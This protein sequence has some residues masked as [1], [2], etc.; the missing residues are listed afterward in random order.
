MPIVLR[1]SKSMPERLA[2]NPCTK[3]CRICSPSVM[4]SIPASSCSFIATRTASRCPSSRDAPWSAHGA[5]RTSGFASQDGFGKLPVIVVL[6]M[7]LHPRWIVLLRIR[8]PVVGTWQVA[9]NRWLGSAGRRRDHTNFF[10]SG[11][12]Q[13]GQVSFDIPFI[14]KRQRL[15]ARIAN[16]CGKTLLIPSRGRIEGQRSDRQCPSSRCGGFG[17]YLSHEKG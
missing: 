7:V 10:R 12:N 11:Q 2:R 8:W 9:W 16:N 4:M 6:S 3:C 1:L 14:E 5:Q 15:V 13:A 17:N